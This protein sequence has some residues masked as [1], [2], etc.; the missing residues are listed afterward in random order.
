MVE[1]KLKLKQYRSGNFFHKIQTFK[2]VDGD[3]VTVSLDEKGKK[4]IFKKGIER[5]ELGYTPIQGDR[6]YPVV[7]MY[8]PDD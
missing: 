1:H 8:Y 2:F 6:L 7:V 5:Y 3:L 4:V